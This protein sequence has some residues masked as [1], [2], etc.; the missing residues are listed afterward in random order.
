MRV[1]LQEKVANLGKVGDAVVVKAGYA[2]NFLLPNG[3]AIRA[4]EANIA[5]FEKRR[6]ELEKRAE[7]LVDE[8][9]AR[10]EKILALEVVLEA[11]SSDEG[12]LFGSVTPREIAEAVT[13]AGV[14]LCKS[15]VKLPEGPIRATGEFEADLVLHSDVQGKMKLIVK[16]SA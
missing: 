2:R 4:T 12:K 3:K 7:K 13:A 16:S 15:E 10:L 8:A 6:A 9:K 5:E 14:E 1:I 11:Q